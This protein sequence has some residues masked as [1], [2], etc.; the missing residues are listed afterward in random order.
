MKAVA[1]ISLARKL[2]LYE[3]MGAG[4]GVGGI[5]L[6][7]SV[8][9]LLATAARVIPI[10]IVKGI[11]IG[12]GLSLILNA[13][14]MLKELSWFSN[15]VDNLFW[16]LGAAIALFGTSRYH[17]FPFALLAFVV[18]ITCAVI[19]HPAIPQFGLQIPGLAI[20]MWSDFKIGL[21]T[22]GIGQL[23]LTILNSIIAV[24]HLALDL[25]P[26]R[27]PPS[28]TALGVSVGMMNL[29]GCF[30]GSMPVCH[31]MQSYA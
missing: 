31:G 19:M 9:G 21:F 15:R 1:S 2:S 22:A 23:P 10:P 8:T 4:L 29:T 13:G 12:A 11:Q 6:S 27:P 18:G 17:K 5:V 7:L 24:N 3:T 14:A 30:F 20:P 25:L 26:L 28:V 16:A